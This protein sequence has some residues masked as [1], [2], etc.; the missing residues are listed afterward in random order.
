MFCPRQRGQVLGGK[1]IAT[2]ELRH[3]DIVSFTCLKAYAVPDRHERKD[4]HDIVCCLENVEGGIA[5]AVEKFKKAAAGKHATVVKEVLE[6]LQA[7]RHERNDG[8]RSRKKSEVSFDQEQVDAAYISSATS[9][10][11]ALRLMSE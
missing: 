9:E 4:A 2:E 10:V 3:V 11:A 1:G 5:A 6:I 8:R 7:Y